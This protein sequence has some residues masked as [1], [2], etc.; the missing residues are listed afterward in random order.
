MSQTPH[1]YEGGLL[2]EKIAQKALE[3]LT[4]ACLWKRFPPD[5]HLAS[6]MLI[7]CTLPCT[8]VRNITGTLRLLLRLLFNELI[9]S[10]PVGDMLC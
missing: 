6:M 5:C 2:G 7:V 4:K 3:A 10:C 8:D 9:R 1:R